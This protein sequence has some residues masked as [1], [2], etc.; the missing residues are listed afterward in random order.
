MKNKDTE[1]FKGRLFDGMLVFTTPQVLKIFD[2]KKPERFRQWLKLNYIKP[3]FKASGS[4]TLNYFT[5][6]NLYTIGLFKKLID[7]GLNRWISMKFAHEF[8][9]RDWHDIHYD[10]PV[11]TYM[12]AYGK[13]DRTRSWE[14]VMKVRYT[15]NV[16]LQ[17]V[18]AAIV[19][20][21]SEIK[22]NIDKKIG[23]IEGKY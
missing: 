20:N 14:D 22:K 12:F 17:D 1:K 7:L 15:T 6:Y 8:N 3:H 16:K 10:V 23:R 11:P 2:I 18:E 5:K 19:V 21:L 4:G 13:V 9:D